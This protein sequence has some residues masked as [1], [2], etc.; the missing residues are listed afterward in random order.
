M[1]REFC[2][3]APLVLP[4]TALFAAVARRARRVRD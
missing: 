2:V 4:V 1:A 3:T